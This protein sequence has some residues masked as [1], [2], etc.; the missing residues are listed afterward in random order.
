MHS[1]P[2]LTWAVVRSRA[3]VLV[4]SVVV[5]IMGALCLFYVLFCLA[6]CLF[7]LNSYFDREEGDTHTHTHTETDRQ[8]QREGEYALLF[9]S[10]WCLCDC[11]CSV[12]LS[13]GAMVGLQCM[14]VVFPYHTY[15]FR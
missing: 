1:S 5:S 4:L 10:S 12:A 6:L 11:Y 14:I 8:R 7:N 2:T 15:F 3:A 9:W 13:H